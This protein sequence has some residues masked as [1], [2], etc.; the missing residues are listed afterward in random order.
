VSIYSVIGQEIKQI[1]PNT[2]S[3]TVDVADL[4]AGIYVVK[5]T[6]QGATATSRLVKK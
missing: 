3:T 1:R 6:A 2:A 5:V 4:Q